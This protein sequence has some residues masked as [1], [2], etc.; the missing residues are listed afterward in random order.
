MNDK[1]P[2]TPGSGQTGVIKRVMRAI[3]G[4]PWSREEIQDLLKEADNVID[5]Q[6][7]N[8]LTGVFEVSETQVREVMVPRSQMIVIEKDQSLDEMLTTIIDS[9]HSRFPVIGE[10]RDEVLGILLAKD[11]LKHF[12][13]AGDEPLHIEKFLRSASV[14]P[15][16]KRLNAL[17]KEFRDSHNHMAIVVDEYG[18]VAG[19]LTIEDVLEEIVGEID[20]EHDHEEV[21]F[22]RQESTSDGKACYAVRALTRI[23]DFNEFFECEF[24]DDDYDTIGGLVMHELGRLPARGESVSY[25]GFSFQVTKADSRR[26]DTLL[27]QREVSQIATD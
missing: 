21:A 7:H 5:P 9:G 27:V 24:M 16:S 19:L 2:S 20:D 14:I 23:D 4:E 26:I 1:P 18:G 3:K 6:E 10:D 15:E 22:I 8:M 12:G 13:N 25:D 17:L 11:L